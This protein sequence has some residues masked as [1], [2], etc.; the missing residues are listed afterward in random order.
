MKFDAISNN[1]T[2]ILDDMSAIIDTGT[3][4][5]IGDADAVDKF[6][7]QIPGAQAAFDTVG[8]GMYTFPCSSVPSISFT[9][10]GKAFPIAQDV[11]NAGTSTEEGRC[12]G[13]IVASDKMSFWIVGD[14]FLR[15]VYT[16]FDIG[17]KRVGFADL[18]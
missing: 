10:G 9:F 12:V 17:E 4:L 13:S 3:T 5:I 18:A 16:A 14:V 2:Q 1:S 15:G 8:K 6:Y 7:S 11:F